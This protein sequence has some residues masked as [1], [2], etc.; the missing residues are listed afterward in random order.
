MHAASMAE[1]SG[2]ACHIVR[3]WPVAICGELTAQYH[4]GNL[5]Y[6]R[7]C[8]GFVYSTHVA[9][10]TQSWRGLLRWPASMAEW[11]GK[12]CYNTVYMLAVAIC[13]ILTTQYLQRNLTPISEFGEVLPIVQ[14]WH[15]LQ[16][17]EGLLRGPASMAEWP[18]QACH[19][20]FMWAGASCGDTFFNNSTKTPNQSY[21]YFSAAQV[22]SIVRWLRYPVLK[23]GWRGLLRGPASMAEWSGQACHIVFMWAGAS[24]G[25]LYL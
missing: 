25:R 24:C 10:G 17:W 3:M 23:K 4:Q 15:P 2:Q 12:A 22:I 16:S 13:G 8:T 9:P 7:V 19:I 5:F 20:V 11:S 6:L 18:G 14:M 1:W 21:T